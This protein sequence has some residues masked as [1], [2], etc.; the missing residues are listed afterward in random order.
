MTKV[1]NAQHCPKCNSTNIRVPDGFFKAGNPIL[2]EGFIGWECMECGYMGK[3]FF[4]KDQKKD[5]KIN[6]SRL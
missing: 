5:P 4:I 1:K 2:T 6:S 3:N